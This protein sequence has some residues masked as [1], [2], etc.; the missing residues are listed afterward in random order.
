MCIVP[1]R[2]LTT[3]LSPRALPCRSV[4]PASRETW[5]AAFLI[6]CRPS[7]G[8]TLCFLSPLRS[9][10]LC[11]PTPS[12]V[13]GGDTYAEGFGI[14]ILIPKNFRHESFEAEET[15]KEL[16]I[17]AAKEKAAKAKAEAMDEANKAREAK[18]KKSAAVKQAGTKQKI[19]EQAATEKQKA[20]AAPAKEDA[21]VKRCSVSFPGTRV[22]FVIAALFFAVIAMALRSNS[23]M[24]IGSAEVVTSRSISSW[25]NG[26]QSG[27]YDN[28]DSCAAQE[29]FE[30]TCSV[31]LFFAT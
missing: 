9:N 25:A 21:P 2:R 27:L 15:A 30:T 16:T 29:A 13:Q 7:F 20:A 11:D 6:H 26:Q 17:K 28:I 10:P 14:S 31:Q 22:V 8:I 4:S 18:A 19:K 3:S 5:C 24:P 23:S 12:L 1:T